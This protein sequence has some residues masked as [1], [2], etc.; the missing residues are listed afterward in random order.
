M[1][2]RVEETFIILTIHRYDVSY[3]V[4][5]SDREFWRE[6]WREIWFFRKHYIRESTF[7]KKYSGPLYIQKVKV[8]VLFRK[9]RARAGIPIFFP[10]FLNFIWLFF[11]NSNYSPIFLEFQSSVA[12][13]IQPWHSLVKLPLQWSLSLTYCEFRQ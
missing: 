10:F 2:L 13:R 3:Y 11:W 4:S 1:A 12:L 8:K 7:L 5:D 9:S 6:F